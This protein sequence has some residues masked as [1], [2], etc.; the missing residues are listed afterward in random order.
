MRDLGEPKRGVEPIREDLEKLQGEHNELK[1]RMAQ[2][3]ARMSNGEAAR[4]KVGKREVKAAAAIKAVASKT[5][6]TS[7]ASKSK[8]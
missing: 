5:G 6:K 1:A 2:V 3:E 7:N 8:R 4:G